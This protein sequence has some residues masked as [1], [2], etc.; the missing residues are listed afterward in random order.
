MQ[1]C[2]ILYNI[3]GYRVNGTLQILQRFIKHKSLNMKYK[4]FIILQSTAYDELSHHLACVLSH[5]LTWS[6]SMTN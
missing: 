6:L 2:L 4:T 1:C 5:H 3:Q